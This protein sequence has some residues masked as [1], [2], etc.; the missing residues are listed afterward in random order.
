MAILSTLA[1]IAPYHVLTYSLVFGTTT[2]QSFF[3]GI[4]AYKVLPYDH[5][6]ALQA[7]IFP[8]YFAFQTAA[9]LALLLTAPVPFV[10][11]LATAKT[12][13]L[14]TSLVGAF[15]NAVYLG[16]KSRVILAKR[17][18]QTALEGKAHTDPTASAEMK[19]INKEFGAVHGASVLL[20]MFTFVGF[21]AYG[22]IM[23]EGFLL[24]AVKKV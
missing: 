24:N 23:T 18:E 11:S 1:T 17:R 5:F 4:V 21:A 19:A 15:A 10:G 22:V 16:P 8:S 7:H 20:N 3:N 2:F 14:G 13:A 9:S 6:S 12:V